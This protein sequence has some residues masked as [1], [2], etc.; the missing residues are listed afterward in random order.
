MSYN[1]ILK[2]RV[3]RFLI[4]NASFK[5]ERLTCFQLFII[6]S[7]FNDKKVSL[8]IENNNVLHLRELK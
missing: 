1:N 7:E 5:S 6:V 2:A 4:T 3:N 8:I